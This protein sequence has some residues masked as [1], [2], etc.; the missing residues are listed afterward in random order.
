MLPLMARH[1]VPLEEIDYVETWAGVFPT[2][3]F[4]ARALLALAYPREPQILVLEVVYLYSHCLEAAAHKW[5][6]KG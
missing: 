5:Q 1:L 6:G 4:Y 3:V 2:V